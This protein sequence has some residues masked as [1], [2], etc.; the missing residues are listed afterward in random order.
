MEEYLKERARAVFQELQTVKKTERLPFLNS[1]YPD[2]PGF[3]AHVRELLEQSVPEQPFDAHF[4]L[5]LGPASDRYPAC[6]FY[7]IL[8]LLGEGGMGVVYLA[9]HQTFG[10]LAAIK[11]IRDAWLW[12]DRQARFFGEQS[13][14]SRLTHPSIAQMYDAG[15]L[16]NGTPWLAMEY[17]DGVPLTEH[18]RIRQSS[19]E[20]RLRLFRGICGA[21]QFAHERAV[22]HRDLKPSNVFV[23]PDDTVHLLDFGLAKQIGDLRGIGAMNRLQLAETGFRL[24]TPAYASPEQMRGEE[25]GVFTDI[26]ALGVMLYELLTERLPFDISGRSPGE[27]ERAILEHEPR[28]PSEVASKDVHY[29]KANRGEWSDLDSLC[30]KAMRKDARQRY[31][32]VGALIGDIDRCLRR[33]PVEARPNTVRYRVGKFLSRHLPV[34]RPR[35]LPVRL[36]ES[37]KLEKHPQSLFEVFGVRR[38]E[39]SRLHNL[40]ASISKSMLDLVV[41]EPFVLEAGFR[42]SSL[43]DLVD[44]LLEHGGVEIDISHIISPSQAKS[45]LVFI[46]VYPSGAVRGVPAMVKA[47]TSRLVL[48]VYD[49]ICLLDPDLEIDSIPEAG[50]RCSITLVAFRGVSLD[51]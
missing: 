22:I 43:D 34:G 2:D 46:G 5:S 11:F 3:V 12:P 17:V 49:V 27:V 20:Q 47:G 6:G 23:K 24:M 36:P 37:T 21:V 14:L 19:I 40:D 39:Q 13:A 33:D 48:H 51:R 18:C 45:D 4:D 15:V 38:F 10:N 42:G 1:H 44:F 50:L 16:E 7:R 35:H 28:H 31:S 29:L 25:V 41:S 32:S 30:L 9:E 26:Y 8:R